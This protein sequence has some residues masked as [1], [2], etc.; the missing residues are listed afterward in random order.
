MFAE[1]LEYGTRVDILLRPITVG[2]CQLSIYSVLRTILNLQT[3]GSAYISNA[4]HI[5]EC[6]K[7]YKKNDSS[8]PN[9]MRFP[10]H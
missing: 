4:S 6:H 2:W 3:L 10:L 5:A 1:R 7:D 9:F 8:F